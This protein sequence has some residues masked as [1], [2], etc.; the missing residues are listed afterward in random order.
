MNGVLTCARGTSQDLTPDPSDPRPFTGTSQA[1]RPG[2]GD[3]STMLSSNLLAK[4]I[5]WA[6]STVAD[7]HS[8]TLESAEQNSDLESRQD[9]L[10]LRDMYERA[11]E[12]T[13]GAVTCI[14]IG[15][16]ASAEALCRTS[17]ESSITLHYVSVNDIFTVVAGY[18]QSYIVSEKEQNRKWHNSIEASGFDESVQLAH[19]AELNKKESA[20][21]RYQTTLGAWLDQI[22]SVSLGSSPKW[23]SVFDRFKEIGKE[24]SY[25]TVY[26]ALCS[27]SHADAEDII[28]HLM[29]RLLSSDTSARKDYHK[30]LQRENEWFSTLMIAFA[31]EEYIEATAMFLGKFNILP[32]RKF[33]SLAAEA[34]GVQASLIDEEKRLIAGCN[35]A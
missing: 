25:R 11:H 3:N 29:S 2:R 7:V 15:N 33:Q 35:H 20:L 30:M 9:W 26:A 32:V 1:P 19:R 24:L 22:G 23:P 5:D 34:R 27:Q 21:K 28:N 14:T 13:A 6:S 31:I 16:V 18:F 4:R 12:H 10:V 17:L 8:I